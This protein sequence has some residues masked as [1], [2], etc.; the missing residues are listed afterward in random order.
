M[1]ATGKGLG[2]AVSAVTGKALSDLETICKY[3][4]WHDR[5]SAGEAQLDN[6]INDTIQLLSNLAPWP[7]Y[8]RIDG[9]QSFVRATDTIEAI[10]GDGTTVT[11][12]LTSHSIETNDIG[13]ITSTTNYN[14]SNK[15]LTDAGDDSVTYL[16]DC[17]ATEETSG[18]ITTGDQKILG[19]TRIERVGVVLRSDSSTPLTEIT[20]EEWLQKKRYH[21]ATG[22]PTEYAL[23]K[24]AVSGLP[25]TIMMVYP[26]PTT[27][28]T[29]YYT[30][31][32]YPAILANDSDTTD[33][34]TTRIWLLAEALRTRLNVNDKDA[35][36]MAL[37]SSEF[38]AKVNH[39]FSASR[40]SYMPVIAKPVHQVAPGKWHI[41]EI[42][43]SNMTI[44]S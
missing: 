30:Y 13:D 3:H 9:A 32:R 8:H 2:T 18:T 23:R 33:W 26:I 17:A 16:D 11:I 38:M 40:N 20:T 25:K 22:P 43:R 41:N 6:F 7:E 12:T 35:S 5:T 27:S 1:A 10:S 34:P 28:I 44:T 24:Y 36:G 15:I 37:Y 29:L 14:V 39:A 19:D 4:G 42:N 21:A 31:K